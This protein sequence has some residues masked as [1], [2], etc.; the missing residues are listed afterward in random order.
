[1]PQLGAAHSPFD[2]EPSPD[3]LGDPLAHEGSMACSRRVRCARNQLWRLTFPQM[4]L[5]HVHF[6]P[7]H[8]SVLSVLAD[9]ARRI[10]ARHT[11]TPQERRNMRAACGGAAVYTA[12]LGGH[13]YR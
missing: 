12:S 9:S 1:M 6:I 10:K 11:L 4:S 7:R 2:S 8:V 13:S 3:V 5:S